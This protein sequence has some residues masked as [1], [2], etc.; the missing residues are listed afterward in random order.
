[1]EVLRTRRDPR[2][3]CLFDSTLGRVERPLVG[4]GG[5]L[6]RPFAVP[7]R[8]EHEAGVAVGE[9]DRLLDRRLVHAVAVDGTEDP[10]ERGLLG[11]ARPVWMW[12]LVEHGRSVAPPRPGDVGAGPRS[13]CGQLPIQ[14][15]ER[16]VRRW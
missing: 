3:L 16:P 8:R 4:F 6:E 15:G 9:R 5:A 2:P 13:T 1:V 12:A 7:V 14:G 10:G 11:V